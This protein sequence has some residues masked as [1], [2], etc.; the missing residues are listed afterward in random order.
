MKAPD[1]SPLLVV[2]PW[3]FVLA[4]CGT[5]AEPVAKVEPAV[6]EEEVEPEDEICRRLVEGELSPEL[7]DAAR[8]TAEERFA[9]A[10]SDCRR[11][12][13]TTYEKF[14]ARREREIDC[15]LEATDAEAVAACVEPDPVAVCEHVM[16]I[17]IGELSAQAP[18]EQREQLVQASEQGK[19]ACAEQGRR[20]FA[21]DRKRYI[22]TAACFMAATTV[23][24]LQACDHG[25]APPK[26]PDPTEPSKIE[27]ASPS[28]DAVAA[29][30]KDGAP[31]PASVCAHMM[32][33]WEQ[34]TKAA[35][36]SLG[37]DQRAAAEEKL[38]DT[39]GRKKATES[40]EKQAATEQA[41]NSEDFDKV[42]ACILKAT[43]MKEG[44]SCRG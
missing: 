40:C 39:E 42:G 34:D 23:E 35:L 43:N 25:E 6:V 12:I 22:N 32:Q 3:I 21:Q 13:E 8:A 10:M 28:G 4:S 19:V 11:E 2:V 26:A 15:M 44:S 1:R 5:K 18:A 41:K 14:E 33:L 24:Q 29:A 30:T 17:V 37:P 16:A 31:T 27:E 7:D 38:A 9:L 20:E 36:D